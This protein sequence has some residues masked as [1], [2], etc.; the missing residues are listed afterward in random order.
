M[1]DQQY[2]TAEKKAQAYF[3]ALVKQLD[4]PQFTA[5][6]TEDMQAYQRHKKSSFLNYD[7]IALTQDQ[8]FLQKLGQKGMLDDYLHRSISYIYLRDLGRDITSTTMQQRIKSVAEDVKTYL[9]QHSNQDLFSL[10]KLY[11]IAEKESLE[12]TYF[13][14]M[15]K[16]KHVSSLIPEGLNKVHAQ[17]KLIKIIAGVLMHEIEEL[18]EETSQ[19][20]RAKRLDKAVR[21]GYCYGLTYPFIDD[22]L[23]A[24][25]LSNQEKN[26]FASLIR[27]TLRTGVL[28]P[29]S[30][31]D[32]DNREIVEPIYHELTD[33]FIYLKENQEPENL[34]NF[35]QNA[36]LFFHAQEIDRN[37]SLDNPDYT[38]E[39]VY[40]PIILKSSSSRMI[41]RSFQT[42]FANDQVE[43]HMFYYGIYNQLADD[44]ADMEQDLA[45]NSVT[46][47][48]YF[49]K[50]RDQRPDLINPFAM[51]WSVISYLINNV[52]KGDEKTRQIIL[53]RAINGLKR[54]RKRLGKQQYKEIMQTFSVSPSF[55]SFLQKVVERTKNVAFFDK[56]IRDK[57]V[58]TLQQ[59][60]K[61][62]VRFRKTIEGARDAI[63]QL[64]MI[65]KTDQKAI[66]NHSIMDAANYSLQGDAKRLRPMMTWV[67]ATEGFGL[68]GKDII[69][70]LKAIEYMH[71]A[72]LIFDDLPSQDNAQ[73]RRGRPTLHEEYNSAVAELTA[74]W[75]TQKAVQEQTELRK[76]QADKILDLIAYST[77]MTQDMCMGQIMDLEAKGKELSVEELNRLCLYKTGIGF[78]AALMMPAIVAGAREGVTKA[79][80]QF[81]YHA[82]IAFQIKDDLLDL[83]GDSTVLGKQ[84]GIDSQNNSSTFVTVL[85]EEQAKKEMWKHYCDAIEALENF[86]HNISFLKQLMDYIVQREK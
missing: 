11:R 44:L 82:G 62:K 28:T 61:E 78:E 72:S 9:H 15:K 41:V 10:A 55:D 71:T 59:Q 33:A 12:A 5:K 2:Q 20:V 38:N 7:H 74:L 77:R 69:P 79:I 36:Y 65:K 17:R 40:I 31:W 49:L 75:M 6:L 1:V 43:E 76:Y 73:I 37:K 27:H 3:Q 51:Y 39:E 47:Y 48:T 67:M 46:P 63:N 18:Q 14:L 42:F 53:N 29:L 25:V 45:S 64:L 85:G 26:Q 34:D 57:M 8:Q 81:T 30:E 60:E 23:D 19:D 4:E 50:Y 83:E 68:S 32:G 66:V 21:I 22:L 52:Y 84:A 58:E 86:P 54:L 13:W 56:L 80:K 35:Y 24:S 16:L 70:L